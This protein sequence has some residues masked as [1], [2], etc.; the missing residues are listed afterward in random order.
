VADDFI[1]VSIEVYCPPPR[2][3]D[4]NSVARTLFCLSVNLWKLGAKMDR[5]LTFLERTF[6]DFT[7]MPRIARPAPG[8]HGLA[9]V[10]TAQNEHRYIREWI[11]FHSLAGARHI[12]IYVNERLD[13]VAEITH[14]FREEDLVTLIPWTDFTTRDVPQQSAYAHALVNFSPEFRWM[15]FLDIDEFLFPVRDE[16]LMDALDAYSDLP[17]L[18]LFRGICSAR[19]VI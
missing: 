10:A 7:D 2:H 11:A 12:Y 4:G 19:P 13:G 15:A 8:R 16:S 5:L 6:D 18:E 14:A 1:D 9:V 17:G 3:I